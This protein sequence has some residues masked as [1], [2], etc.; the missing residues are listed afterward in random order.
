MKSGRSS[1]TACWWKCKTDDMSTGETF[2]P[3]LPL[4]STAVW[5][6]LGALP[7]GRLA[8][9]A[10]GMVDI[11]PVNYVAKD[12]KLYFRTAQGT[13]LA[14]LVVNNQVAFE[15]DRVVG[16]HVHSVVVHGRAR[17]LETQ[18]ERE[19]AEQLPLKPWAPTYKYHFVVIDVDSATG[20]EFTM[21][22]EPDHDPA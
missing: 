8:V 19:A 22:T 17:R 12:H 16:D 15:V 13:K 4:D 7:F 9:Q 6:L 18:A 21:T 5:E 3:I 11:F 2:N 1:P 20:R 14:S 10:A